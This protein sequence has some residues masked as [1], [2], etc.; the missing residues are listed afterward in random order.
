[1]PRRTLALSLAM[2][3]PLIA[4][5]AWAIDDEPWNKPGWEPITDQERQPPSPDEVAESTVDIRE[6]NGV[7]YL[8]GGLGANERAWLRRHGPS[9]PVALQFSK[10]E[11]GAFVSSVEVIIRTSNG[12]VLF[13]ATTDGPLIYIDLANGNYEATVRY[14][15]QER[16]FELR[17]PANER[18][19]R[20][21]NFQ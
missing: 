18:T 19:G 3:L 2:A 1:M 9:Y 21:I 10:G 11:R 16:T 7:R 15:G 13:E 8:T 5:T 20:S 6:N 12:Q 4:H 14:Q 17:V